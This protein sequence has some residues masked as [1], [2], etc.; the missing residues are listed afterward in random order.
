MSKLYTL[1]DIEKTYYEMKNAY[2]DIVSQFNIT[3]RKYLLLKEEYEELKTEVQKLKN[4]NIKKDAMLQSVQ[5]ENQ[6]LKQQLSEVGMIKKTRQITD[7]QVKEIKELR[8]NGLSYR[9]IEKQTGWSSV[10]INR[11]I[12]GIYD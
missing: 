5:F 8:A 7:E 9:A 3:D 4:E 12:K 10:T 1:T 11:A 6:K 2:D